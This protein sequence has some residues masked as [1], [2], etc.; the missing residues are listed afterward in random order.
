MGWGKRPH[1]TARVRPIPGGD[2]R[3]R[4]MQT[5]Q[6]PQGEIYA[7]S[8]VDAARC[9]GVG[10][11]TIY[12]LIAAGKLRKFNIGKR[13]LIPESEIKRFISERMEGIAS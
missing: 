6:S 4:S 3:A 7:R 11:S 13:A 10:R 2:L 5:A 8:I 12:E 1:E 9:I